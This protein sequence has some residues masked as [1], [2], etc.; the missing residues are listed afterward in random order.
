MKLVAVTQ[1][2]DL[3]GRASG[4]PERRDTLDQAWTRFLL[5]ADCLA[6]PLPNHPATA[7]RL[8]RD[9][10]ID[11]LLL[12]GGNDFVDHGGFAS[13]RDETEAEL[14]D[15]AR[16]WRMPVIGV[17]RG[18]QA[19]QRAFQVPLMS[20]EGHVARRQTID[21]DGRDTV[22]N[23][24]HRWGAITTHPALEVWARAPDG[25]VKAVR[26]STE[27]L[28]GLMWHPERITPFDQRDIA[29]FRRT[30]SLGEEVAA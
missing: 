7:V 29:L 13:E 24:F 2:V 15:L 6:V 19:L 16:R 28:V 11:G 14:L 18:M 3:V 25:V 12:S 22:V 27:P 9:L 10:P 23:S 17:C 30:L 21:I 8:L 26:H 4:P 5:A 20:V 1:N